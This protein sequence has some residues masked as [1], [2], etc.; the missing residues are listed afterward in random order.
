MR[1]PEN[2]LGRW[3]WPWVGRDTG[4][5]NIFLFR[6][7]SISMFSIHAK[8]YGHQNKKE[9]NQERNTKYIQLLGLCITT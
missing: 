2:F 3:F 4:N 7:K 1:V 5:D 8:F 6:L 9:I